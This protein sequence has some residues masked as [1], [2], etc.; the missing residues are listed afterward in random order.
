MK[1]IIFIL[2]IFV[3]ITSGYTQVNDNLE[4]QFYKKGNWELSFSSNIGNSGM[5]TK[6]TTISYYSY[7]SSQYYNTHDYTENAIYLNLGVSTGFYIFNGLSIEPEFTINSYSGGFSVT[8]LGNLCYTFDIPQKN[9]YPYIKFGYGLSGE[10]SNSGPSNSGSLNL[11]TIN[12]GAG[13]KIMYFPDM[14]FKMEINYRNL[15][16]SNG[17]SYSDQSYTSSDTYETSTS[18]ISVSLGISILF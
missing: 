2:I 7:D 6:R 13:V 14:A 10:P 12:A 16:G 11:K 15:S 18:I 3:F 4:R 9:I 8:M 1:R 17:Y 5:Q